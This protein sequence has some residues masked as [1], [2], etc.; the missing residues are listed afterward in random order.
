MA[1][2]DKKNN[3][4]FTNGNWPRRRKRPPSTGREREAYALEQWMENPNIA[5][6]GKTGMVNR[7]MEV[8]GITVRDAQLVKI[9]KQ[10]QAALKEK[11]TKISNPVLTSIPDIKPV[12]KIVAAVPPKPLPPPP[13]IPVV[14]APG[15]GRSRH[16]SEV[17]YDFA[18][19][20]LY[21][22]P[23]ATGEEVSEAVRAEFGTGVGATA[24]GNIKREIGV[25]RI[26]RRT[27]EGRAGKVKHYARVKPQPEAPAPAP[28]KVPTMPRPPSTPEESIKA[29]LQLLIAELPTLRRLS[30][31]IDDYGNPSVEFDVA[32]STVRKGTVQ[33]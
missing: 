31:V 9:R 33:L 25:G 20:F 29:T 10:A 1:G 21:K 16:D 30:V 7:L 17:R 5:L 28:K 12:R 19:S 23:T 18:R 27:N 32:V 26:H 15:T 4:K 2:R 11:A 22:H 8:F 6:N 14:Q 24:V 3:G 13:S